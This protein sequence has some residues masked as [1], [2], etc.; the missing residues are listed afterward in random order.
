MKNIPA[1]NIQRITLIIAMLLG[2][3]LTTTTVF[4]QDANASE[5]I[6]LM[7]EALLAR[8]AGELLL[9]KE[10]V[11]MLIALAPNDTNVQNLLLSINQSIE[12]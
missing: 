5:K 2:L 12:D 3:N 6:Q 7:S 11:E 9:A 4:A 1:N 8:D 10:K